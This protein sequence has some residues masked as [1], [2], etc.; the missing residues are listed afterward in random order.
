MKRYYR[1]NLGTW[2]IYRIVC[3]TTN[4][5]YIGQTSTYTN[6]RFEEHKEEARNGSQRKLYIA[7][8]QEGLDKFK[9][10]ILKDNILTKDEANYWEEYYILQYNSFHNG[11]NMTIGGEGVYVLDQNDMKEVRRL[12]FNK[13]SVTDIALLFNVT[14]VDVVNSLQ[15]ENN[16]YTWRITNKVPVCW[17]IHPAYYNNIPWIINR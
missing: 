11:Y 15:R 2:R 7:M 10:E 17:Y 13:M 14:P 6:I 16:F 4:L 1:P 3:T 12:Y 5:S 9:L 8:R